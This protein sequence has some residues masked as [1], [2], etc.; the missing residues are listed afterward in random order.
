[1]LW[2]LR[3]CLLINYVLMIHC[4][5]YQTNMTAEIHGDFKIGVLVSV[6][7]QP[8]KLKNKTSRNNMDCGEVSVSNFQSN[9]TLLYNEYK[10]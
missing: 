5:N 8:L 2:L 6:H 9:K 7:H 10:L 3:N 1:M 4:L